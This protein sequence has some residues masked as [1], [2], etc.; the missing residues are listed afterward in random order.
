VKQGGI[1]AHRSRCLVESIG[2]MLIFPAKRCIKKSLQTSGVLDTGWIPLIRAE[3]ASQSAR[4]GMTSAVSA[5]RGMEDACKCG[6]V[7]EHD[8]I[9]EGIH[10][11][12]PARGITKFLRSLL[13]KR[14]ASAGVGG[15]FIT[16][17]S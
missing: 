2:I 14:N 12:Y 15:Q 9:A 13:L 5:H 10:L 8:G 4:V 16:S 3:G 1:A 6:A 7:P 17:Y 11:A